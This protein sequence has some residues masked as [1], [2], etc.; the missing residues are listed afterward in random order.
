MNVARER[1]WSWRVL[2][3]GRWPIA[4][5][6]LRRDAANLLKESGR[7]YYLANDE[8]LSGD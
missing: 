5:E 7:N 1:V 4:S 3:V 8:R 2:F 6:P